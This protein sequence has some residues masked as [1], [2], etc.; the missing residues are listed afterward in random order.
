MYKFI[1]NS[2]KNRYLK[3]LLLVIFLKIFSGTIQFKLIQQKNLDY[4]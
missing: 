1:Q 4:Y 3:N 2:L